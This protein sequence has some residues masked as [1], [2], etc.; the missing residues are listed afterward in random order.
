MNAIDQRSAE[1]QDAALPVRVSDSIVHL[2]VAANELAV[3]LLV[4]FLDRGTVAAAE[5]PSL[6]SDI[7]AALLRPVFSHEN[8][9]RTG[10]AGPLVGDASI[11]SARKPAMAI[12][13]GS[14][15]A[16]PQ[17]KEASEPPREPAIPVEKS[18]HRD[19]LV[20]LEDGKHYRSLRRHLMAKYGMTPDDYRRK[21]DLPKDYPMVAPSYA[22]ERSLVAKRT[23]LGRDH[24]ASE[25]KR[26]R[27]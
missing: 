22:E 24:R 11:I 20:C 1:Q 19:Y 5:L 27:K 14:T 13:D 17:A 10:A 12:T 2:E 4:A 18:V 23:G 16:F 8:G 7:R 21:W 3:K 25:P 6:V 26:A 9:T 15:A